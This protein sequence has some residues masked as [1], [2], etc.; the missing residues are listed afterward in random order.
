VRR[1]ATACRGA[2]GAWQAAIVLALGAGFA[3][4]CPRGAAAQEEGGGRRL[5]PEA[6][7]DVIAARRTAVYGGAGLSLPLGNYLRLGAVAA[8][9]LVDRGGSGSIE[10]TREGTRTRASARA[11]VLVRFLFDPFFQSRWAP[12]GGGGLTARYDEGGPARGYLLAV[13]GVEG[14]PVRGLFPALELGIGGGTRVGVAFRRA[15]TDRR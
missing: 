7:L 10:G 6:R 5:Q 9:G 1:P 4:A 13:L 8:G 2:S 3:A 12:Y 15:F 14:P 11:D